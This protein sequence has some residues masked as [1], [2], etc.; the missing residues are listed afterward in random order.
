MK[1]K[2]ADLSDWTHQLEKTY[3]QM[4]VNEPNY[5]GTVTM[6]TFDR[7][8]EPIWYHV[9]SQDPYCIMDNGYVWMQY[10]PNGVGYAVTTVINREGELVHHYIDIHSGTLFTPQQV[11]Y[12]YDLFLDLVVLPSGERVILDEDELRQALQEQV[13][14][15]GQ[16]N[17]A[18]QILEELLHELAKGTLWLDRWKQDVRQF[19]ALT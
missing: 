16:F 18:Y 5:H 2:I 17:L 6:V 12:F 13:V 14:T 10:F 7:V 15:K 8:T 9:G 19:Q 3:R 1:R 11:P 4:S